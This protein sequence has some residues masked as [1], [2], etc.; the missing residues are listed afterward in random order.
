M[1]KSQQDFIDFYLNLGYEEKSIVF[2][3]SHA[4]KFLRAH[5]L[6]LLH[7]DDIVNLYER[8]EEEWFYILN[9]WLKHR[10]FVELSESDFKDRSAKAL[11]FEFLIRTIQLRG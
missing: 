9:R 8:G 2:V 4:Q 1:A 3:Y 10:G 6:V 11:D 7:T 5:D